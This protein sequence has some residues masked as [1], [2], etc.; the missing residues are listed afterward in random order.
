M[1]SPSDPWPPDGA[2]F[3]D[4]WP[5]AR[6]PNPWVLASADGEL[7]WQWAREAEREILEELDRRF[8]RIRLELELG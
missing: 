5:A 3:V 1:I 2:P 4:P 7:I 8:A 6:A